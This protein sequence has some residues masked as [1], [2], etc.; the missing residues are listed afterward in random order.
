MSLEERTGIRDLAYSQWHR[1]S[2]ITRY[3]TQTQAEA[4]TYID[5]D[6][7][8]VCNQ[9]GHVLALIETAFGLHQRNKA[10]T[11]LRQLAHQAGCKAYVV[12]YAKDATG[13][14]SHFAARLIAPTQEAWRELTP[15]EW[16]CEL[17][18]IRD[19]CA[20][21]RRRAAVEARLLADFDRRRAA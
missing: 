17:L 4:L 6:G 8:E 21:C 16:A 13:D 5:I 7:A 1:P 3:I 2:R 14:C 11:I 19:G 15:V 12:L 20:N 18:A 10:T 9:C